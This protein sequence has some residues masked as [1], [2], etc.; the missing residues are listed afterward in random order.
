MSR[1]RLSE[2]QRNNRHNTLIHY[3]LGAAIY[4]Y[5]LNALRFL[6]TISISGYVRGGRSISIVKFPASLADPGVRISG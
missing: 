5:I 6:L 1:F 4:I 2:P 3:R